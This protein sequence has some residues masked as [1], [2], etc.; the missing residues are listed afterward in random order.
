MADF[1]PLHMTRRTMLAMAGAGALGLAARGS[2]AT[3]AFVVPQVDRLTLQVLDDASTFGP[4]LENLTLPGLTVMRAGNGG[5]PNTPRM[6]PR[7]L[8]G[9]FGLSILADSVLGT[10]E[11]RVLIDFG[12]SKVPV[13]SMGP[14]AI[15][16][17]LAELPA[18][19]ARLAAMR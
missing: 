12:Y 11:R 3:P 4:F 14:D 1:S 16:S 7:V 6:L 8:V 9:E 17:H 2:S 18:A 15:I 13:A 10:S 19:L 5:P